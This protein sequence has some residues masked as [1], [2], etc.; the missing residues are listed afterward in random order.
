M[1]YFDC[2]YL[3][4]KLKGF[5]IWVVSYI[6]VIVICSVVYLWKGKWLRYLWIGVWTRVWFLVLVARYSFLARWKKFWCRGRILGKLSYDFWAWV[7]FAAVFKVFLVIWMCSFGYISLSWFG[8]FGG[9]F[10]FGRF[11]RSFGNVCF[12]FMIVVFVMWDWGGG[13]GMGELGLGF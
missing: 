10:C 11:C 5:Y 12:R 8:V 6:V 2:N 4:K 9:F 1:L 3:L 7:R 13:G